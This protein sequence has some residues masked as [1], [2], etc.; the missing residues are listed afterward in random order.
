MKKSGKKIL[1]KI[2]H[3]E[4]DPSFAPVAKAFLKDSQVTG[5]MM[6]ASYGLKVKGKIFAMYGRGQFVVKLPKQRVDAMVESGAGK[7]FDPGHRR[8]MKEWVV[9]LTGKQSWIALAK[10]AHHYVGGL[11]TI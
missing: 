4:A 7:R 8:L 6:M 1:K 2:N 11:Q 9:V 5:G 3:T 10:E